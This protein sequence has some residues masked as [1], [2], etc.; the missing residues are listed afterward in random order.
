MSRDIYIYATLILHMRVSK[1]STNI[2]VTKKN[3]KSRT[4]KHREEGEKSLYWVDEVEVAQGK[5]VV[6]GMVSDTQNYYVGEARRLEGYLRR[7]VSE[8]HHH[9]KSLVSDQLDEQTDALV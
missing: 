3:F 4:A 1:K 5:R 7:E 6:G 8:N 2:Q 9:H